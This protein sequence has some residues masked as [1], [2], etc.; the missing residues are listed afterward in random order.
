MAA[1]E[2]IRVLIHDEPS[3]L[4]DHDHKRAIIPDPDAE[5]ASERSRLEGEDQ[6]Q[7]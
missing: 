2:A 7:Y 1:N 3:R 6:S 4:M 5:H